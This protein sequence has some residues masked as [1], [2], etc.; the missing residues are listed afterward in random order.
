LKMLSGEK[1][2]YS[3]DLLILFLF[4]FPLFWEMDRKRCCCGLCQRVFCLCFPLGVLVS[5]L[6]FR[7]LICFELTFVYGV[8]EWSNFIFYMWL[9][10]FPS[11]ICRRDLDPWILADITQ[12]VGAAATLQTPDIL[13]SSLS[14]VL[15]LLWMF[16]PTSFLV[17]ILGDWVCGIKKLKLSWGGDARIHLLLYQT[18]LLTPPCTSKLP[19][20]EQVVETT[21]ILP[22][23][24]ILP[25]KM[26]YSFEMCQGGW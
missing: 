25:S 10:S 23:K 15:N 26:T 8:K 5:V 7:S 21:N 9:S 19:L 16:F 3:I 20:K 24:R 2:H 13:C 4:L 1:M 18:V 14:W 12:M 22:L 11:A 17:A 6:T